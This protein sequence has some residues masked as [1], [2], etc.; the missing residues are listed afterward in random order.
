MR[1]RSDLVEF[2]MSALGHVRLTDPDAAWAE[3]FESERQRL[4]VLSG[5]AFKNI[6]HFGSTAVPGLRA[7]PIVDIMAS[8]DA[9]SAVDA[10]MPALRSLGYEPAEVGFL[11]RRF[12]RKQTTSNGVACH[13]HIV[14]NA[15]WPNKSELLVR[16]WLIAHPNVAARYEALKEALARDHADDMPAYTEAKSKFLRQV[17]NDARRSRGLPQQTDWS[18]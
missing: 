14:A 3:L 10:I 5:G 2:A 13:L 15:A 1:Q 4:T 9:L 17:V 7:K 12:L 6:A 8:V 18:E 11:K 16:D